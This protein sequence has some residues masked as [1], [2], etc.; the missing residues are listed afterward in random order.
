MR[1]I[2]NLEA[3]L[4]QPDKYVDKVIWVPTLQM[5]E[6]A[7]PDNPRTHNEDGDVTEIF[8]S[9]LAFGWGDYGVT[10]N[11]HTGKQTGGH[12]RVLAA[13][14]GMQHDDDWF[15][16]AWDLFLKGHQDR[17]TIAQYHQERYCSGY[18]EHVP[19]IIT[20]LTDDDQRSL[21]I[22]L[23]NDRLD[24][25]NDS[26]KMAELLSQMNKDEIELAGWDKVAAESFTA[27]FL[28]KAAE[29]EEEIEAEETEESGYNY[30]AG[31]PGTDAVDTEYGQRF[32]KDD[33][34]DYGESDDPW[35]V[36]AEE[37]SGPVTVTTADG[38]TAHIA[39][40]DV[41]NVDEE[42]KAQGVYYDSDQRETR[43]VLLYS[44]AQLSDFKELFGT[45]ARLG[46]LPFILKEL[47]VEI[48]TSA[49]IKEWRPDCCLA[50]FQ[51]FVE[52]NS[53]LYQEWMDADQQGTS[54]EETGQSSEESTE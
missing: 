10:F 34:V 37:D 49:S 28:I 36:T 4:A 51:K 50:V 14:L 54:S 25:R 42:Q 9:L 44:K 41:S 24:G 17:K 26:A 30:D 52:Q 5:I 39:S 40:V 13:R 19:V 46:P 11:P 22:R 21:M 15:E 31:V 20:T 33:A 45:G 38:E 29:I 23:N 6:V 35:D 47:G 43:A 7:H 53:K 18:W 1:E 48:N 12:G 32:E 3:V 8:K 2:G 16:Q 27:A